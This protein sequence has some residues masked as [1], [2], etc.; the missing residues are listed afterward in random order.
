M[1]S[2][3]D[4]ITAKQRAGERRTFMMLQRLRYGALCD[5]MG[6]N[7]L[8]IHRLNYRGFKPMLTL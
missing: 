4:A 6:T 2:V 3:I 7:D 1:E 8:T 5:A